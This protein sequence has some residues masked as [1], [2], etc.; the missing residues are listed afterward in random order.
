MDPNRSEHLSKLREDIENWEREAERLDIIG[1][2]TQ[3]TVIRSWM[4][5]AERLTQRIKEL[6]AA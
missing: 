3:S 2:K 6:S 5:S 4:K 1:N